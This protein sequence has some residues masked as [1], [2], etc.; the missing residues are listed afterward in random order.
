MAEKLAM[1][2]GV[3][4]VKGPL[5]TWPAFSEETIQAAMGPLRSG[6]VNYWTGPI[7]K[8]FEKKLEGVPVN[9]T[10]EQTPRFP[11]LVWRVFWGESVSSS[12][13]TVFVNATTGQFLERVR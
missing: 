10:L 4:A 1:Q 9:F 6:K 7:G 3:P 5:P 11:S 12:T 8:E 2:G 13:Y